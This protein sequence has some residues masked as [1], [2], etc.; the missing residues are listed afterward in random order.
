ML[1]VR[2]RGLAHCV[3]P[4]FLSPRRSRQSVNVWVFD[5]VRM[6]HGWSH[7]L[8]QWVAMVRGV[9]ANV[10]VAV[11]SPELHRICLPLLHAEFTTWN[12]PF[13]LALDQPATLHNEAEA[14]M[15][16]INTL[17]DGFVGAAG[18][19]VQHILSEHHLAPSARSI[20]PLDIGGI[21][22][23]VKFLHRGQFFKVR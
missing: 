22:G 15:T 6:R 12:Q 10:L 23:G 18:P 20:P 2:G 7:A 3:C 11:V 16:E 5:G 1:L 17:A 9:V 19:V 14:R 4:C 13:Q 21:A 8:L